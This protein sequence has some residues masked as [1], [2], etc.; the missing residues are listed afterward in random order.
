MPR[1]FAL[2]LAVCAFVVAALPA[3]GQNFQPKAIRFEGAPAYSDQEL[4]A[5]AGLTPG[6]VLTYAEMN[7]DAQKLVDSG[8]FSSVSFKFDGQELIFQLAPATGLIPLRLQNL[9]LH[10]G[11]ELDDRL[12]HQF[13]LYH[14]LLPEQGGLTE[15]VRATLEQMLAAQGVKASVQAAAYKDSAQHKTSAVSFAIAS[16]PVLVGDVRTEGAIVALDPKASAIVAKFPGTPYDVEGSPA[17]I[18]AAF[19]AYYKDQGYPEPAVHATAGGKPV[20]SAD[21]LRIPFRVSIVPGVQYKLGAIRL[22][23]GLLV[24]QA[25]FDRQFHF[26][27]GDVADGDRLR[28]AWKFI[29]QS[30][31]DRGYIKAKVQPAVTID[32]RS[33]MASYEVTV[34]PGAAYTMGKLSIDNVTD[35]LRSAMLAAWKMPAGSVFNESVILEFFSAHSPNPAL[36]QIFAAS[37]YRYTL[38]PND[39]ARTVDVKLTLENRP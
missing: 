38:A 25:D 14:G 13:P 16:P 18:E 7:R 37:N 19:T 35:D 39:E 15:S 23:P 32:H 28:A 9:P 3:R 10:A 31:H 21:A 12:H 22:A 26:R 1:T 34:E 11:K 4:L 36:E 27:A 20:V 2:S 17:A 6:T 8:M 33:N 24:S 5:A 30:Y 29:E